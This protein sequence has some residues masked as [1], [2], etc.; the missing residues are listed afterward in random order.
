MKKLMLAAALMAAGCASDEPAPAKGGTQVG[1]DHP[2]KLKYPPLDFQV[3]DPATFR[4]VLPNGI[5]VYAIEDHSLPLVDLRLQAKGGSFWQPKGKEGLASA[6]GALMRIGG[7]TTR[8]PA[9]IDQAIDV[10]AA[11]LNVGIADVTGQATLSVLSK[12]LDQGLAIFFD[13]LRNPGFKQDKLDFLRA[14][15]MRGMRARNDGTP[16]IEG[17]EAGLLLYGDY[18]SNAH[19]TKASVESIT[20]EDLIAFHKD[21]FYPG[22]FIISA[23]GDFDRA[24]FLKK[25]EKACEGWTNPANPPKREIPKVAWQPKPGVYAIHKEG[26][27][28]NQ[29]RVTIGHLG[30]DI[31]S[32]DL[33]AIRIMSYILGA[34]GFSSRLTQRVRTEEGLAYDVGCDYRPGVAFTG[35]FRIMFQSKSESC[36]YA[37]K[38][39]MEELAKMREKEVSAEELN[40]A[41]NFYLDGFPGLFFGTKFQ[42]TNT[43]A[44]AEINN[45]PA[46]YFQTWREK[47]RSVTAKDVLRVAKEHCHPEQLIF[48][49]TGNMT[50]VRKGDGKHDIQM[51]N[52]GK[53]TDVPLPDPMTLERKKGE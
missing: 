6:C 53:V 52:F 9:D 2:D 18:P 30:I 33:H 5:V 37:A 49:F 31:N 19:P 34:G 8:D 40:D 45:Y 3:P 32:P 44:N 13:I 4:S 24:E 1:G 25:L 10:M 38:L 16:G 26:K 12:D 14:Q 41:V 15:M 17:R 7:T 51:E 47:L 42:T 39:C 27:Q 21:V 11:Q 48:V 43:F 20:R 29:G 35:T 50:D 36:L 46:N 23:A 28:I 22:N